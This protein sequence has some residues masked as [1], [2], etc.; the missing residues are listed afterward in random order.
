MKLQK[1]FLMGEVQELWWEEAYA[2][3][4]YTAFVGLP[5]GTGMFSK[6]ANMLE[7]RVAHKRSG[8][9]SNN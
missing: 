7:T 3:R 6:L 9:V 4:P 8:S 1:S 5:L 2:I